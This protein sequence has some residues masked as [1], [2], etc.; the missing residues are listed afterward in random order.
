[1]RLAELE[2]SDVRA[3]IA[4]LQKQGLSRNTVRLSIAP[5]KAMLATA[6]EDG[7]IQRNAAKDVRIAV[8]ASARQ[9]EAK[10]IRALTEDELAQLIAETPAEWRLMVEFLT[11]TGMRIGE[12][13][14]VR[15]G[16]V[17][18]GQS[19]V[20]VERRFYRNELDDPKSKF[21]RRTIPLTA[22]M[23]QQ[24][25]NRRLEAQ[26]RS[27]DALVFPNRVGGHLDYSKMHSSW[28]KPA[29]RRAGVPWAGFHTLRHTCASLLFHHGMNVVVIQRW[30]GHHS[31][32]FTL[33]TYVHLVDEE[34]QEP[35]AAFSTMA[36]G[37][38]RG[39]NRPALTRLDP[40]SPE[41]AET[42]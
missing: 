19:R 4:K 9:R 23:T 36:E 16:D 20:R 33:N 38:K 32:A 26:D 11:Q 22:A 29:C 39:A 14:A 6:V 40:D 37:G 24:L 1:M 8:Q 3:L 2:P 17:D 31:P 41:A 30:L 42:A 21:G 15:W 13:I 34:L 7:V 5:L 10:E 12:C 27:D 28:L 35:P 25:Y 18:F